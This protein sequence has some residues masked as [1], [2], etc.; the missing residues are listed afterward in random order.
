MTDNIQPRAQ[1]YDPDLADADALELEGD[2]ALGLL[3]DLPKIE[4]TRTTEVA[5]ILTSRAV[6]A[7]KRKK[8]FLV[9]LASTGNVGV[10]ATRAGWTRGTA[11]YHRDNDPA[12]ADM[13][14]Q[15]HEFS[16][17]L[18]EMEMRRR[19]TEGVQRPIYQQQML[20]GHE[21]V[22]SD[23]LLLAMVKAKR[24]EYREHQT[25][26]ANVKGGVL[27]VPGVAVA[28]AWEANASLEQAKHRTDGGR[29]DADVG[30]SRTDGADKR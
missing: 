30:I 14:D 20:V 25:I 21:T 26:D 27:I 13:W 2:R 6:I 18:L 11:R 7:N 5:A 15:A 9:A 3:D 22:Y 19:A 12:F 29:G 8:A 24:R 10:A 4:S 23:S 28:S 1:T 17:D 16:V